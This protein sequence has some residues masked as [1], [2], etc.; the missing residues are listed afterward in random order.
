[1]C[2]DN[3]TY[4]WSAAATCGLKSKH[5]EGYLPRVSYVEG[6]VPRGVDIVDVRSGGKC[7]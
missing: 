4:A 1:V 3:V 7:G 6:S 2:K 5:L